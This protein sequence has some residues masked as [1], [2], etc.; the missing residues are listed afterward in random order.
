MSK[1]KT[2]KLQEKSS[3]FRIPVGL[4]NDLVTLSKD[5]DPGQRLADLH[6]FYDTGN[7]GAADADVTELEDDGYL[8]PSTWLALQRNS[9][10]TDSDD[11]D[12]RDYD[13]VFHPG[14]VQASTPQR[15]VPPVVNKGPGVSWLRD[16]FQGYAAPQSSHNRPTS[17]SDQIKLNPPRIEAGNTTRRQSVADRIM[18]FS[19]QG[20][21]LPAQTAPPVPQRTESHRR[22]AP[23][24][25][26]TAARRP[27][28]TVSPQERTNPTPPWSGLGR[29]Y[30]LDSQTAVVNP[31]RVSNPKAN[32]DLF[33]ELRDKITPRAV[34]NTARTAPD[35]DR[36]S[37]RTPRKSRITSMEDVP[38]DISG[39]SADGISD[40]LRCLNL[41]QYAA[42]MRESMVD[43]G[44]L[45]CLH[46]DDLKTEF[47]FT[48]V[49]AKKLIQFAKYGWRP[50]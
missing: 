1:S 45:T 25:P 13:D 36:H 50:M 34:S 30:S 20:A 41:S 6:V 42:A 35:A 17:K 46:E 24:A 9:G 32:S 15:G 28:L 22:P 4:R 23:P 11:E 40:C 10:T 8:E 5:L 21:T 7:M 37:A 31:I 33:A 19:S 43:G 44:L 48:N 12:Y 18:E 16:R 26:C 49:N 27:V 47:G 29:K 2:K 3:I 39:L 38:T 14:K